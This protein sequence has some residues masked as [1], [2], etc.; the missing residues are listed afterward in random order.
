VIVPVLAVPL[1][2][3]VPDQPPPAEHEVGL[4]VADHEIVELPPV[5][6]ADGLAEIVTTGTGG[7]DTTSGIFEA[8]PVPP[9]FEQLRLK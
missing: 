7:M 8:V 9:A 5:E 6:I 3:F 4:F 2:D 1:L